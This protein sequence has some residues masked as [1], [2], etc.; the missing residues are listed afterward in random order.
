[1]S[2]PKVDGR[3]DVK[4]TAITICLWCDIKL[5]QQNHRVIRSYSASPIWERQCASPS[6]SFLAPAGFE[7]M[8]FWDYLHN[9]RHAQPL[10]HCANRTYGGNGHIWLWHHTTNDIRSIWD[11]CCPLYIGSYGLYKLKADFSIENIVIIFSVQWQIIT[12]QNSVKT[13]HTDCDNLQ[14]TFLGSYHLSLQFAFRVITDFG[15]Q[16][17]C[18]KPMMTKFL[19]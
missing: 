19:P 7:L 4:Y 9:A 15:F 5:W 3:I 1:M 18:C 16:E 14:K 13:R 2:D 17:L 6:F 10:R 12:V 8:T 11:Y